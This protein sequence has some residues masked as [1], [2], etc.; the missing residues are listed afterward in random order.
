MRMQVNS[1]ASAIVLN[2][3]VSV[4]NGFPASGN[5]YNASNFQC[6]YDFT[7]NAG[8]SGAANLPLG[9]ASGCK[10]ASSEFGSL[11]SPAGRSAAYANAT[12]ALAAGLFSAQHQLLFSHFPILSAE[13]RL[14]P[15]ADSASAMFAALGSAA[16]QVFF[17]GHG[18]RRDAI[19]R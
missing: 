14:S 1:P 19:R 8:L 18:A 2:P 17:N 10:Y 3:A 4:A 5:L 13:Q 16:P 15:W 7:A 12:S 11:A 6:A 9:W